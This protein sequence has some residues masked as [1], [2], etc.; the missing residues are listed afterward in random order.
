MKRMRELSIVVIAAMLLLTAATIASAH[1]EDAP[2][3]TDLI[4]GGGNVASAIDAGN[5]L[6]WNDDDNLYVKYVT[7]GWCLTETHLHIDISLDGIPQKKGNPIPGRFDYKTEHD[8]VTEYTYAIPQDWDYCPELYIAAHAVVCKPGEGEGKFAQGVIYTA[9]LWAGQTIDSGTVTVAIE[10]E[11][12]VVTYQT[13]GGW[14]MIETQLYVGTTPPSTCAPGQFPY[15]HSPIEPP[16]TT[17]TYSIPLS[18]FGVGCDDTLYIATHA[19]VQKL[20]SK[21]DPIYKTETAWGWGKDGGTK[22]D[23]GWSR[24]FEVTITCEV[25]PEPVCETAWGA[26]LDFPGKNWATYFD[27]TVQGL[28]LL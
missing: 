6:V 19:T 16:V 18:K 25:P 15:K 28:K 2:F 27:Y 4:A 9:T 20:N 3:T 12:L 14:E 11:N 5:V 13:T 17:D 22:C 24:Y 21:G 23:V 1:T 10:G 8:C 7:D 26:G